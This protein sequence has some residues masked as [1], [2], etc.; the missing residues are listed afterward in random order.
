M[1]QTEKQLSLNEI[2]H[3]ETHRLSERFAEEA[4]LI[5]EEDRYARPLNEIFHMLWAEYS[6]E[7]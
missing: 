2:T 3:L 4:C 1:N 7:N 5:V 6:R